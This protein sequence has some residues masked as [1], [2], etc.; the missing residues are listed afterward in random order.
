MIYT[1]LRHACNLKSHAMTHVTLST[2]SARLA[3]H[4]CAGA[5]SVNVHV[6][7][8]IGKYIWSAKDRTY[9]QVTVAWQ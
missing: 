9:V 6:D 3:R 1:Q 4:S 5:A 7:I 8:L 2:L